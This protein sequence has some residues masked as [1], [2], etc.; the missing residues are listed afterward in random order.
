MDCIV[1]GVAKSQT[2]LSNFHLHSFTTSLSF[3]TSGAIIMNLYF[4]E[5]IEN[6]IDLEISNWK[7]GRVKSSD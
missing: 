4:N 5:P 7:K 2:Q 6:M 1:H 3:L